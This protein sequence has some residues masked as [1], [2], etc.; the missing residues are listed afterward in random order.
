MLDRSH[1]TF[2]SVISDVFTS[3]L[4]GA[5]L[6]TVEIGE[7]RRISDT[8]QAALLKPVSDLPTVAARYLPAVGR[9]AVGGDWYDVIDMGNE[10]RG[11]IVGDCVGH[12][13]EAA[14][15]MAQLRSAA[16]AMILE[17]REP[18]AV[19]DGLS[20]FAS[21]IEGAECASVVCAVFDRKNRPL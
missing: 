11:L 13:L 1:M 9:L 2:L 5:Y 3:A 19:L 10:R 18:A 20:T 4:D 17:G 15:V 12:G 7:Y 21:S 16:R 14:T 6:R 8:L